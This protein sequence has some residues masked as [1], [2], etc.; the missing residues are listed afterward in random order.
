MKCPLWTRQSS[1]FWIRRYYEDSAMAAWSIYISMVDDSKGRM[2]CIEPL[3]SVNPFGA[4]SKGLI[5]LALHE[6]AIAMWRLI[7]FKLHSSESH[8]GPTDPLPQLTT[9]SKSMFQSRTVEDLFGR[10][11]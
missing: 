1:L 5:E 6:Q 7:I 8:T 4:Q 2:H 9:L 11:V 10:W 3:I